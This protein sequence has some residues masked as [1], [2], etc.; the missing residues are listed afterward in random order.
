MILI[1]KFR[2]LYIY[3]LKI[4]TDE[5]MDI[6]TPDLDDSLINYTDF[7]SG[8]LECYSCI[9]NNH[10]KVFLLYKGQYIILIFLLLFKKTNYAKI[11]MKLETFF[12]FHPLWKHLK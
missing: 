3:L 4:E 9:I 12:D 11:V 6:F 5:C 8:S 2:T 1:M 10:A 7:V